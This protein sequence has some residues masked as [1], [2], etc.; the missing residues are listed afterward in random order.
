MSY[1]LYISFSS[2]YHYRSS[3]AE[4]YRY[5]VPAETVAKLESYDQAKI[6]T[7]IQAFHDGRKE[8]CKQLEK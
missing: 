3:A 5:D 1:N 2:G 8:G 4:I 7:L 6:D